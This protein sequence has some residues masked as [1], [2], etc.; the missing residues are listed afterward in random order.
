MIEHIGI[1]GYGFVGK[2]VAEV[3]KYNAKI[4]I[5][6][7]Q[8]DSNRLSDYKNLVE[9][10]VPVAFVCVPAPTKENGDIDTSIVSS[11]LDT[12]S[13]VSYKG[14]VVIKSTIPPLEIKKLSE[15]FKDLNIV[16]SPEFLRENF[17]RQDSLNPKSLIFGG[18]YVNCNTVQNIYK[19]HATLESIPE[20]FITS[21]DEAALVKYTINSFLALKVAFFN[22]I[23]KYFTDMDDGKEPHHITWQN[24]IRMVSADTRL[25][26]THMDVPGPDG[27]FGY[28][29]SCFP[30]DVKAF[31]GS[32]KAGHLSILREAEL[33]NTRVKLTNTKQK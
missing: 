19:R 14:V 29:G 21:L 18:E 5:L 22:E 28:G 8:T 26:Y 20:Y 15:T 3:F 33:S 13:N 1:I 12:L 17:W 32:D 24:F 27:N 25:G 11:V 16:Y 6:D 23:Y 10:R 31:I 2:G 9:L 30:K 4:L 7:P